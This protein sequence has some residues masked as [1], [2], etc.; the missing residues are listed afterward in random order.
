MGL[1]GGS[2]PSLLMSLAPRWGQLEGR[3]QLGLWTGKCDRPT[4]WLSA[5]RDPGA[6]IRLPGAHPPLEVGSITFHVPPCVVQSQASQIQG[7]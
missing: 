7:K 6:N 1:N 4:W 5:P 3:A 2:R